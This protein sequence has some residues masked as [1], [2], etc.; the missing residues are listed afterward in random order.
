MKKRRKKS[1]SAEPE[2]GPAYRVRRDGALCAVL[3][4]TASV[5]R[6]PRE[7]GPLATWEGLLAW[8]QENGLLGPGD[9][10][11]LEQAAGIP[12]YVAVALHR[13]ADLRLLLERILLA[14]ASHQDPQPSDLAALNA[15]LARASHLLV[16]TAGGYRWVWS[17]GDDDPLDRLLL[18]IVV[19]AAEVL[20]SEDR[21][22]V[23]RC[24]GKDCDLLFVDRSPGGRRRWCSQESCGRLARARRRY[25]TTLKPRRDER[26]RRWR[27][28]SRSSASGA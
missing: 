10:E 21:H 25:H 7:A 8:A 14:L 20:A 18:P 16:R 9:A 5:K 22:Q 23:R 4:N 28:G 3:V 2:L 11:Q 12:A 13:V 17:P 24:G 1:K 19:S 27:S 6:R 26:R 15:E